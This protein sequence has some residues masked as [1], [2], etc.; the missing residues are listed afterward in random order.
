M[1]DRQRLVSQLVQHEGVK[2]SPYR[3]SEGVL[4]IGV[5]RNLEHVGISNDEAMYLLNND[6]D[7]AEEM[8]RLVIPRYVYMCETR[9]RVMVDMMFNLGWTRLR[10]FRR[11]MAALRRADYDAASREMLDS[12]WA[13]QVKGRAVRLARMMKEGSEGW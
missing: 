3:D 1:L 9:K 5:G 6:I 4:T 13:T 7:V 11:M 12:R 2:L 8:C 10:G